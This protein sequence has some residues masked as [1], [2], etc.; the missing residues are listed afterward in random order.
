MTDEGLNHLRALLKK[1]EG[2]R[3]VVY[4]DATGK[5]LRKGD[6]LK[7]HPTIGVGR[8]LAGRGITP[9]ETDFLLSTDIAD[10][11]A[12]L[13]KQPWWANLNEPRQA[14]MISM[15]FM[16]WAALSQFKRLFAALTAQSWEDASASMLASL[17]AKQ[18]KTRA[19]DLAAIMRS[20]EWPVSGAA[21]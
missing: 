21:L 2:V 3:F 5:P 8:N 17:W 14:V 6:T 15:A 9:A 10:C 13:S 19:T 20:G 1:H 12:I 18:T 16:G 11:E 4:D 7:G